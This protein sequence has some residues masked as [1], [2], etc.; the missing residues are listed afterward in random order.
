ML[1][2]MVVGNG[3]F[4]SCTPFKDRIYPFGGPGYV[5]EGPYV[6]VWVHVSHR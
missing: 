4:K 3:R 6:I 5:F 2:E 1:L